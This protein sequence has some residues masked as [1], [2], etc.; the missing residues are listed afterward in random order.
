[1]L[2]SIIFFLIYKY[3][4][5]SLF[6]D[7]FAITFF[8]RYG[9]VFMLNTMVF[10]AVLCGHYWKFVYW[11]ELHW[12]RSFA[13]SFFAR[14]LGRIIAFFMPHPIAFLA[15][16]YDHYW[17]FTCFAHL[18]VITFLVAPSDAMLSFFNAES[19]GISCHFLWPLLKVCVLIR[20]LLASLVCK[21]FISIAR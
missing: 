1:M 13:F 2:N 16:F 15:I 10:C 11:Q 12:L 14:S 9:S 20:S 17:K 3:I 21:P 6:M 8:A 5:C 7:S 18:F 19:N 4:I